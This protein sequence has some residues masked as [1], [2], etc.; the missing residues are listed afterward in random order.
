MISCVTRVAASRLMER[1]GSSVMPGAIGIGD[2]RAEFGRA[3]LDLMP[4]PVDENHLDVERAQD[5]QIEQHV[6]KIFR[7]DDPA[8]DRD[9]KRALAEPGDILE[10][11]AE[12]GDVHGWQKWEVTLLRFSKRASAAAGPAICAGKRNDT[13]CRVVGVRLMSPHDRRHPQTPRTALLRTVYH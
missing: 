12:I 2:G 9:D 10:D 8:V 5:G 13:G 11:A 4:R 3:L 7:V 1:V 6:G